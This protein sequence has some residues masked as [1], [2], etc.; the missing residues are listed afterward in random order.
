MIVL[1]EFSLRKVN[2]KIWPESPNYRL[3]TRAAETAIDPP[4]VVLARMVARRRR[5]ILSLS[6]VHPAFRESLATRCD[7]HSMRDRLR[8]DRA[9]R[10]SRLAK[11]RRRRRVIPRL[12]SL[13]LLSVLDTA[14][15][16]RVRR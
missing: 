6:A 10:L 4:F 9:P 11:L 14:R 2:G 13:D 15:S 3:M 12:S 1:N 8:R 5:P 16:A 7:Y